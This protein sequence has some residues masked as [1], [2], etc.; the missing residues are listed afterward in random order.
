[1]LK[2]ISNKLALLRFEGLVLEKGQSL[3]DLKVEHGQNWPMVTSIILIQTVVVN[4]FN[5]ALSV[6]Y[7]VSPSRDSR[8]AVLIV[9]EIKLIRWREV[10]FALLKV[11]KE[12]LLEQLL[13][14][15]LLDINHFFVV[16]LLLRINRFSLQ[17]FLVLVVLHLYTV[18]HVS[19]QDYL[20]GRLGTDE[21]V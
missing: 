13:I 20:C 2:K 14:S 12:L 7:S 3:L 18:V 21:V 11:R 9:F 4:S 6:E 5:F 19:Q 10:Y 8:A 1:M 16:D 15:Q 17:K